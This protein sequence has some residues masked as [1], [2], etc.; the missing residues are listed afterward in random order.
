M[1]QTLSAVKLK[2]P[3]EASAHL[4]NHI[5]KLNKFANARSKD[6]LIIYWHSAHSCSA[7]A[8]TNSKSGIARIGPRSGGVS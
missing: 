1:L 2:V 6:Y 3:C 4:V 7:V 5:D 8:C